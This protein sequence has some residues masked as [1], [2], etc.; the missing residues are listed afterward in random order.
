[1]D[2]A[3]GRAALVLGG[4]LAQTLLVLIIWPLRR[5]PAERRSLGRVYRSLAAY[6]SAIPQQDGPPEPHTLAGTLSP[7]ADPQPFARTGETFAFQALLDEAERVRGSLAALALH[8]QRLVESDR[9]CAATVSELSGRILA[10]LADALEY[11]REPRG[12]PELA[13]SLRAC[14][15]RL[16]PAVPIDPLLAQ[17]HA[18]CQTARTL[19][20]V[21]RRADASER[22]ERRRRR[23]AVRDALITLRANL[24]LDSTACR[25]AV[26]LGAAVLAAEAAARL[27]HFPRGYWLPLTVAVMLKPDFHDTFA[28]SLARVGGTVL[29]A[30]GAVALAHALGGGP[31]ASV[32]IVLMSVWAAYALAAVNAVAFAVCVTAYVV[33]LLTLA[34]VPES[35]AATDRIVNTAIAGAL[36]LGAYSIWPTWT[37]TEMRA[38]V[39]AMLD[40]QARYLRALL[41]AYTDPAADGLARLDDLRTRARRARSNTEALVERTFSEPYRRYPMESRTAMG[42]LAANR[43]IALAALALHAGLQRDDGSGALRVEPLAREVDRSL[44][45][46]AASVRDGSTSPV[47]LPNLHTL[48]AAVEV[49]EVVR[50]EISMIVDGV[51]TIADLLRADRAQRV[52]TSRQT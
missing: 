5:F 7:L 1:V 17:L 31:A 2:G 41:M 29:G 15:A 39:A 49:G 20:A 9:A 23:A 21:P 30:G 36:A 48:F 25:H 43:R 33:F 16:P 46:L 22:A 10:E 6:A 50:D 8:R 11:G 3:L 51:E 38:A 26:R 4:G 37:A 24:S 12:I 34:G 42:L 27:F 35:S 45:S 19:A 44:T 32:A 52:A 18:A 14:A 40:A 13:A 28:S 47:V